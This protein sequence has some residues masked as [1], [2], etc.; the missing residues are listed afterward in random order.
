MIQ[1]A[2][3]SCAATIVS[4]NRRI[5]QRMKKET[6]ELVR[7]LGIALV[8]MMVVPLAYRVWIYIWP[9][10]EKPH[11]T[12]AE[13]FKEAESAHSIKLLTKPISKW[14]DDEAKL[15]PE[16]YAWL[17]DQ[18]NEILPWEWTEEARRKDP[19]GYA[20]C[21]QRIWEARKSHCEKLLAERQ[22]EIKHLKRELQIL[23]TIHTHRTNQIAR[24]RALAATNTFP[25]QI[26][27][28]RLEKGRF[29]GWNKK[30]ETAECKDV[31][32]LTAATN[33]ICSKELA[34][35]QEEASGVL[36]LTDAIS[37]SKEKS[38]LY[39]SLCDA[40]DK[41]KQIIETESL[42]DDL[43]LKSLVENLKGAL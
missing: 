13:F 38:M 39:A 1:F 16:I 40:C 42:Q 34:A 32:S 3:K 26:T 20:K 27:L 41:N 10:E 29:W 15:E 22:K 12:L 18:G 2:A 11:P 19:R 36:A 35:A 31:E 8:V 30:F 5:Q 33:S 4:G 25:C 43:L 28:E 6:K 17:K 7:T 14:S 21:W 9:P 23:T 24:L 37:L